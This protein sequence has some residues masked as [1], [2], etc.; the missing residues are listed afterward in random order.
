[1]NRTKSILVVASLMLALA[2]TFSCSSDDGNSEGNNGGDDGGDSGGGV[3]WTAVENSPFAGGYISAIAYGNDKFVAAG[4]V[5]GNY[6][7][8]HS[9]DGI[10]WTVEDN[11]I[12]LGL[13]AI[14][15]GNGKF[16]A[17]NW[18]NSIMAYSTDGIAWTVAANST[19][20]DATNTMVIAYG[21]DKFV[22]GCN[23]RDA[24]DYA[25][26]KMAYSTDGITWTAIANSTFNNSNITINSNTRI[27]AIAYGNGKFV[28]GGQ[29]KKSS[30]NGWLADFGKMAY[31][32]NGI[33]WTSV[34]N[35]QLDYDGPEAIVY[36]NDKFVATTGAG[37][38]VYSSDGITWTHL[39]YQSD[40]YG[41]IGSHIAYGNGKFVAAA[42][43]KMA[44]SADGITWTAV[45]NSAFG[46]SEITGIAYGNGKFVAVGG[47]GKIAHW[48][49][50]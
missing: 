36:G 48:D 26:V 9:T 20:D 28:A 4:R 10:A 21:N 29:S 16:V 34:A 39:D 45:E 2:L 6:R 8:A 33:A 27:D 24:N 3:S 44:Y 31:S 14:A 25:T 13:N 43:S 22:V 7:I 11:N 38:A 30:T 49:G 37:N 18:D 42:Y 46:S 35:S 17:V 41:H 1:M 12:A 23:C 50:K 15:Y 19:F 47:D 5:G 32:S 40:V